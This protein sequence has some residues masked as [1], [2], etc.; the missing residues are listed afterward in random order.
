MKMNIAERTKKRRAY[1]KVTTF[2][3]KWGNSQGIRLPKYLLNSVQ[4][5]DNDE[6]QIITKN[7]NIIIKKIDKKITQHKTLK[8]RLAGYKKKHTFEE[9]DTNKPVG[10][11]VW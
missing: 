3:V 6:V 2:I 11:E 8:E 10:K 9:W 5:K 7:D 4:L 1:I